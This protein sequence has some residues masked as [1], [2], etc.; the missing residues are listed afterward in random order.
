MIELVQTAGTSLDPDR[1][2]VDRV[3]PAAGTAPHRLDVA[4]VVA[5]LQSD[6]ANGLTDTEARLRLERRGPNALTAATRAPAWRRFAAQFQSVLVV[7]LLIATGISASL[8]AFERDAALPYEALAI[9]AVVLI[10][11]TLGH[12]QQSRAESAVAALRAMAAPG[13]TVVRD[14]TRQTISASLLVPGD[15]LL[16]EEGNLVAADARLIEVSGLETAEATLTGE[17]LPV[18]KSPHP[19]RGLRSAIATTWCSRAPRCRAGMRGLSSPRR[20]CGRRSDA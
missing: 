10:N 3:E 12:V 5:S 19:L 6:A 11:A 4:E 14:T 17:S 8:W 20:A 1:T 9:L 18:S 15:I 7:L 13:A 2:D 16:L